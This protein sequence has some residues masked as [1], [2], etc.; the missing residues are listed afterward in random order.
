MEDEYPESRPQDDF[1][2]FAPWRWERTVLIRVPL[3][4]MGVTVCV[5]AMF[6]AV[7]LLGVGCSLSG[8]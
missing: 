2:W 5:G 3:V 1:S 7:I 8:Q 6:C 4:I